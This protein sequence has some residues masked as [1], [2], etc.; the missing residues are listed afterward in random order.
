MALSIDEGEDCFCIGSKPLEVCRVARGKRCKMGKDSPETAPNFG[1]CASQGT[2]YFSYKLHAMCDLS[3]V[4]HLY[5]LTK[6]SVHDINYLQDIKPLY[7][8]CSIFGE[9][10]YISVSVQLD[11][12]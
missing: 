7:H 5:N 1:F 3:G 9:K 10:G 12:F 11:L 2:Y 8:D 4:S 6:S